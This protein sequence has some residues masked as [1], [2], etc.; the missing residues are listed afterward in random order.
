MT[1]GEIIKA[2]KRS[3]LTH[4]KPERIWLYGSEADGT[5]GPESDIDI[6]F[7]D[8]DCKKMTEILDE[9]NELKTLVKVDVVNLSGCEERFR[10]RVRD[11]GRVLYSAT[12][13]LRFQD[14]IYNFSKALDAFE[15]IIRRK[16]SLI[17]QGFGD[18][19]LDILVKRFE[20]TFEMSWKAMKRYL[21]YIGIECANPRACFK[22]AY[23]Q[24]LIED[25]SLWLDMIEQR[26]LSSHEY[27]ETEIAR[28]QDKAQAYCGAFRKL[29][30]QLESQAASQPQTHPENPRP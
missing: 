27:E 4:A 13:E 22:E 10:N 20:F 30:T 9:V 29:K 17:E 6:A 23:Q 12:K 3:I 28:L 1:R 15:T 24:K 18:M 8:G 2:V 16:T 5:A 26:N 7:E 25:E 14:S 19:F 21:A 11:T